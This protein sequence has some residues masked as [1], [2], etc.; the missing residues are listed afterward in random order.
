[1]ETQPARKPYPTDVTDDEWAFLAPYLTLMDQDAPQRR[2]DL[3]EANAQ[4]GFSRSGRPDDHHHRRG[5][6]S[7]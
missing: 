5:F 4:G 3:R 6:H 2:H 1:M 7:R